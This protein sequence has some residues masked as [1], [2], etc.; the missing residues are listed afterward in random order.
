MVKGGYIVFDDTLASSCIGATDVVEQILIARDNLRS[1]QIYPHHVF[2]I[3][4]DRVDA[5][6]D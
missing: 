3:G 1:E 2:R 5:S 4:L 6:N